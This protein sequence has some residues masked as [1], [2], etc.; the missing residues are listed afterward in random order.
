MSRRSLLCLLVAAVVAA[1][2]V[3][4]AQPPSPA[5]VRYRIMPLGDSITAGPGCWRALLWDRLQR[6]GH[7][8]VDFVG[9]QSGGGCSVPHDGDHEGH[10]G[11]SATDIAAQGLLPAW[12]DAAEPNIVLMHLGTND[13][14]GGHIPLDSVLAAYSTLVDRM[15]AE[16]PFVKVLVAQVI[17]MEPAGCAECAGRVVALNEAIPAWAAGKSTP[18]SPVTVVDQWTGFDAATDTG[19]GVHPVD[20]GFRKMADRW[21]P[22]LAAAL[23][24]PH[25]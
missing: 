21:Y 14:W 25:P 20:S 15:R 7:V 3:V 12:L 5:E 23:G 6:A 22:A 1:P 9:S 4:A 19:D 8:N 11:H 2:G 16:N 13:M 17:P 18:R 24:D 10:G